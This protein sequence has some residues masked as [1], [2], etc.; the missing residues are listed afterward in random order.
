MKELKM[1]NGDVVDA[2]REECDHEWVPYYQSG[3]E[4]PFEYRCDRC[5]ASTDELP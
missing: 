3:D 4:E 1:V 5:G 2:D